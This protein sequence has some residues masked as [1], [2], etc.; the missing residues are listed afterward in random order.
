MSHDQSNSLDQFYTRS[1]VAK[2]CL[3]KLDFSKYNVLLEPSAGSGAFF[4]LLPESKRLGLDLEPAAAGIERMDYFDFQ[5]DTGKTYLTV[6]NPPFGKNSSLAK[7]FFNKSAEFSETIAFILP[8]TFRKTST[9]NQLNRWFHLSEE[10]ILPK[11]SF[12]LPDG[13]FYD[14][15]CVFQIWR[16]KEQMRELIVLPKTHSDFQFSKKTGDPDFAIRRVGV[17]AGK[18]F[19]EPQK[20]SE[21]SH[22]F[23]KTREPNKAVKIFKDLWEQHWHPRHCSRLDNLKWDT[24]GNPSLSMTEL[25]AFYEKQRTLPEEA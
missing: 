8:R 10:H 4:N 7:R 13:S 9:T 22:Y 12:C 21:P 14:V 23:I 24:A 18:V 20:C 2:N 19:E 25:V 6:G 5:H 15:P 17:H 11:E 1:E 3:D 16:R